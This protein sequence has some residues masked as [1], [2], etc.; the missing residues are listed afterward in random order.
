MGTAGS[1]TARTFSPGGRHQG[2]GRFGTGGST[3]SRPSVSSVTRRVNRRHWAR[4]RLSSTHTR[5]M[6]VP[7]SG[8]GASAASG[9]ASILNCSA[10]CQQTPRGRAPIS[11]H[12]HFSVR[13]MV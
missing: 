11:L 2:R 3:T 7:P 4:E 6:R 1:F 5:L 12:A 13:W 9:M 10:P 8:R